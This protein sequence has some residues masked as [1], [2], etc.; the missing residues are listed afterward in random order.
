MNQKDLELEYGKAIKAHQAGRLAEAE[1]MYG[2]ILKAVPNAD[3]VNTNM[4]AL[5]YAKGNHQSALSFVDKAL[6][7]NPVNIDAIVNRATILTALDRLVDAVEAFE[8]ALKVDPKNPLSHYNL[9]SL[10]Y[11]Q[12]EIAKAEAGFR[13]AVEL[14]PDFYQAAFN[15][16]NVLVEQRRF[17]EA[18]PAYERTLSNSPAHEGALLNLCNTLLSLGLIDKALL[19]LNLGLEIVPKAW[20]LWNLRSKMFLDLDQADEALAAADRALELNRDSIDAWIHRGNALRELERL[21]DACDAYQ[22][23]LAFDPNH[24]GALRNLRR[25]SAAGIP[26]WHFHML[27]DTARNAAFG[28]AIARIVRPGDHVLDIGT[29][30]GLLA[31]MAAR[32]GAA[33]VTACEASKNIAEVAKT[34]VAQN[35]YDDVVEVYGMHSGLLKI[36]THLPQKVD[37][38]VT[39]ILD[40]ALLGEFMLP[41]IRAALQTLAK[42]G[43]RVVP[44]AATVCAQL[45]HLPNH[46]SQGKLVNVEG[47]DLREFE[48]FRIPYEYE[49]IHLEPTMPHYRSAVIDIKQ[50]D[51]QTLD[52]AVDE[53]RPELF[54]V[55][56]PNLTAGTVNGLALWFRLQLDAE[57]ELSS[58]PGGELRHWGQAVFFFDDPVQVFDGEVL[59]VQGAFSDAM[60]RFWV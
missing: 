26:S 7:V 20:P 52:F 32:A 43:A 44:A 14:K 4:A 10:H 58:G 51:F 30:S 11:Q 28:A 13:K 56:F 18:L 16:G 12:G 47:F 53:D 46:L 55:E 37:V 23:A 49:V 50:L 29:G 41:S 3:A 35:G 9:G 25:L 60:W 57:I 54:T 39:E 15:L 36:G 19:Q 22:M 34:I 31:M 2:K 24:T 40:A 8:L 42:P 38:I 45:V 5:Q 21:D 17:H 27:A 48:R 6:K 1:T 59:E 33:K